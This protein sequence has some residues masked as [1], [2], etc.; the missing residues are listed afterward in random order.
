MK[1]QYRIKVRTF[2]DNRTSTGEPYKWFVPQI[3]RWYWPFNWADLVFSHCSTEEYARR[4]ITDHRG[5][6]Q[7]EEISY[8]G[9]PV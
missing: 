7:S 8:I 6:T 1:N 4:K 9:P 3:K 5:E 2:N